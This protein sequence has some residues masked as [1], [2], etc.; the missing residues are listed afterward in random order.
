MWHQK[1]LRDILPEANS[2]NTLCSVVYSSSLGE[3]ELYI[4]SLLKIISKK[5]I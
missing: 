4:Y 3:Y 2:A 5:N 1:I